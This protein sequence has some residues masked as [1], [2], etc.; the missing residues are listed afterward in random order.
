MRSPLA[1][2]ALCLPLAACTTTGFDSTI[3]DNL[4][5]ACAV[6]QSAHAAFTIIAATGDLSA[7]SVRKENAAYA[8]V[9]V[10]CDDPSRVTAGNAL[11][12]VAGAYAVITV[13]L[14][15]AE[16]AR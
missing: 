11:V 3:R 10:F 15:E 7:A 4:P 13:A 5:Q 16:A 1:V 9:T 2:L 6:L 14:R 8:G 12:L